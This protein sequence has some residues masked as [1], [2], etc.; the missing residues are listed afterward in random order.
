MRY[1]EAFKKSGSDLLTVHF[2]A[3]KNLS[4]TIGKIKE[5]GMKAG[6]AINPETD[7]KKIF[8]YIKDIDLALVMSV[9]PGFGGQ[10]FISDVLPKVTLLREEINKTKPACHLQIDGGINADNIKDVIKAGCD[11]IVCGTAVFKGNIKENIEK[12]IQKSK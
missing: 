12:I 1:I 4:E 11:T 9:H 6:V 10:K 5:A 3:C 7:A 8:P 2:E